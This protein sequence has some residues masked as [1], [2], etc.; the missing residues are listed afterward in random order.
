M[1]ARCSDVSNEHKKEHK[2]KS[3]CITYK[4]LTNLSKGRILLVAD[5]TRSSVTVSPEVNSCSPSRLS[6]PY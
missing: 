2:L 4:N 3:R 1:P 6:P 5:L